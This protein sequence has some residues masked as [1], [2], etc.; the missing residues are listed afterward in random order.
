MSDIEQNIAEIIQKMAARRLLAPPV[1][2]LSPT[3]TRGKVILLPL[4]KK[5]KEPVCFQDLPKDSQ[6]LYELVLADDDAVEVRVKHDPSGS[7]RES[8]GKPSFASR[9]ALAQAIPEIRAEFRQLCMKTVY[10]MVPFPDYA[11]FIGDFLFSEIDLRPFVVARS[12][13]TT[14]DPA[15]SDIQLE[16][17]YLGNVFSN[18]TVW[19]KVLS[20][21]QVRAITFRPEGW[22]AYLTFT[23]SNDL[24][25][26]WW[27]Y[28][29]GA[30]GHECPEMDILSNDFPGVYSC[31]KCEAWGNDMVVRFPMPLWKKVTVKTQGGNWDD[32]EQYSSL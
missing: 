30:V 13:D 17:E 32:R 21:G 14:D 2:S 19:K 23:I 15:N 20:S 10:P 22:K 27:R 18:W 1:H 5:R 9:M 31:F 4:G 7:F 28:G 11:R 25:E 16:G 29:Y 3:E 6:P 24:G 12:A 26:E 8:T